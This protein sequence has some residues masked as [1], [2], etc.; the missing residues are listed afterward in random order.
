MLVMDKNLEP[1]SK[2]SVRDPMGTKTDTFRKHLQGHNEE[3]S[4]KC[5]Q[6]DYASSQ[7][8]HLRM[9]LK[10][11]TGEKNKQMQAV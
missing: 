2:V 6:C 3:K 4:N 5:N 9:Y 1:Q 10:I 8:G 11:H 7:A